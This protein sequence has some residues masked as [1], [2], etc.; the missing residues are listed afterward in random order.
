MCIVCIICNKQAVQYNIHVI[1]YKKV[2]NITGCQKL[3]AKKKQGKS[4]KARSKIER[5]ADVETI[6]EALTPAA[7]TAI[8]ALKA[9]VLA[10][11][12]ANK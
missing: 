1:L 10:I 9:T 4:L 3:K 7:I 12:E 2:N 6:K 11:R 8:A 5:R